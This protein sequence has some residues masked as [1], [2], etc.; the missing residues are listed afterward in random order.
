MTVT[1]L[2]DEGP[3]T[4]WGSPEPKSLTLPGPLE[5]IDLF[6][7]IEAEVNVSET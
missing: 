7:H 5:G 1:S 3:P 6:N 2:E 4:I